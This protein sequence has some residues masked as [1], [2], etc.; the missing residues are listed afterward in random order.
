MSDSDLQ[1]YVGISRERFIPRQLIPVFSGS[2]GVQDLRSDGTRAEVCGTITDAYLIQ[3]GRIAPVGDELH[4]VIEISSGPAQVKE[5]Y[6]SCALR[7]NIPS[8]RSTVRI[9][10]EDIILRKLDF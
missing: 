2:P 8:I 9:V 6:C 1:C 4:F 7:E 5:A 10:P 3:N